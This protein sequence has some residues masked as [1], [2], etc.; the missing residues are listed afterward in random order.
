M[1]LNDDINI[2]G[3]ASDMVKFTG[4]FRVM[5]TSNIYKKEFSKEGNSRILDTH[6]VANA[7][8]IIEN[9]D[10]MY[11]CYIEFPVEDVIG[12]YGNYYLPKNYKNDTC[13]EHGRH[14]KDRWFVLYS[15]I[16][17]VNTYKVYNVLTTQF[18]TTK[19]YCLQV[20]A[21]T[22]QE[23]MSIDTVPY[24]LIL[25]DTTYEDTEKIEDPILSF[26]GIHKLRFTTGVYEKYTLNIGS[27]YLNDL[28]A[29]AEIA[30]VNV[31]VSMGNL[32]MKVIEANKWQ[33][34]TVYRPVVNGKGTT[35]KDHH[36][37]VEVID[38]QVKTR[39]VWDKDKQKTIVS[40]EYILTINPTTFKKIKC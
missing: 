32:K 10:K 18:E 17:I 4:H 8:V 1:L 37:E 5:F 6:Y 14:I 35:I 29:K 36:F 13:L 38:T 40:H 7:N 24:Q 22:L 19:T 11:R 12:Y 21:N 23:I 30:G 26:E 9:S 31:V 39:N 15:S 28:F 25:K 27:Q 20:R 16:T 34:Y 33:P 3:N 2:L